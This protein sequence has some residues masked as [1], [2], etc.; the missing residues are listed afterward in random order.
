M[1]DL[2][3]FD[4]DDT[5]WHT[6]GLYN[7]AQ[8]RF[9]AILERYVSHQDVEERLFETEM[10]NVPVFGYGIKGFTLSMIETAIELTDGRIVGRDIQ[11]VI[12][13]ARAMFSAEVRPLE[14]VEPALQ[15][16]A[17]S[18]RLMIVTKGDLLDQESKIARSGLAG[19]FQHI[20]IVSDKTPERYA[21]LLRRHRLPPERFLM[22]GNSVRSDVL[23]VLA[24]G[25]TAVHIPYAVTWAH[26]VVSQLPPGT[27]P[28]HELSNMRE[29][30]ALVARLEAA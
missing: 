19:Y 6:E 14:H 10:R 13:L 27:R 18:H 9:K 2:I 4:A 25:G 7:D 23:P 5:L 30:A 12:D 22:V 8:Q 17:R 15:T 24:L 20:E 1:F 21:A 11:Q 26:E 3:G 29:L 16:L 28:Y